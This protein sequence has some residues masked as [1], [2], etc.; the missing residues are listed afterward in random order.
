M[1][2]RS[3]NSNFH[4]DQLF[5]G[6]FKTSD[7]IKVNVMEILFIYCFESFVNYVKYKLYFSQVCKL[8]F[9]YFSQVCELNFFFY[10][11]YEE[12]RLSF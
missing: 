3:R 12:I 7:N 1:Q 5:W 8:K 10:I 9:L 2:L 4:T 6:V 11:I